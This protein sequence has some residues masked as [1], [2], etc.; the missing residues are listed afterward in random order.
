MTHEDA[1]AIA[2]GLYGIKFILL[3]IFIGLINISIRISNLKK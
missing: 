2:N 1:V 3:F